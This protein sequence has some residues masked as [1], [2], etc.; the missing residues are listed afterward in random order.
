MNDSTASTGIRQS[1]R[2]DH[3][4]SADYEPPRNGLEALLAD[5]WAAALQVTPVGIHDDFFELGGHS[6]LA[7]ELLTGIQEAVG[8]EI[9]ARTLF[10]QPTIAELASEIGQPRKTTGAEDDGSKGCAGR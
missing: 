6:L 9:P 2:R 4:L 8:V 10:L 7:A 5:L 1:L 3:S